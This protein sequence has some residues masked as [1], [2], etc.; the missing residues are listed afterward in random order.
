MSLF[1][2]I[3]LLLSCVIIHEAGHWSLLTRYGV[4]VKEMS[5]G[6]GQS[7]FSIGKV[8]FG[9]LPIGASITPD[10]NFQ[11]LTAKQRFWVALAGPIAS[12]LYTVVLLAVAASS[13]QYFGLT[14]LAALNLFIAVINL[15]P[16]P[17]LD[18]YKALSSF[19]EMR[20]VV[21]SEKTNE[22]AGRLGNGL[23][24]GVGFFVITRL[25]FPN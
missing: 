4:S 18:G 24:Y 19:M 1:L 16:I 5:F 25:V 2:A 9:I 14:K 8:K 23:I 12:I 22:L 17:P 6:L 10:E 7:F 20:G 15:I 11:K 13:E 3:L 21:L